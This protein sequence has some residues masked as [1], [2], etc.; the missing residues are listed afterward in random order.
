MLVHEGVWVVA[1]LVHDGV[2][3]LGITYQPGYRL[4]TAP[5]ACTP[6]RV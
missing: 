1:M 2:W 3:V 5:L 4:P 6:D